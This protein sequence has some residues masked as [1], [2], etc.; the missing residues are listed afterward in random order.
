[1]LYYPVFQRGNT[2]PSQRTNVHR[3]EGKS[4]DEER[5]GH[6]HL[7]YVSLRAGHRGSG[8]L[9]GD[10]EE[11]PGRGGYRHRPH[12]PHRDRRQLRR[13]L[14]GYPAHP[15]ADPPRSSDP[16]EAGRVATESGVSTTAEGRSDEAGGSV[17]AWHLQTSR[18][19]DR[20]RIV[21]DVDLG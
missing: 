15:A 1:M 2:V 6:V 9:R 10:G 16:S 5:T 4:D 14:G 8:V 17:S 7:G 13:G 18:Q 12:R 20:R 21:P 3:L 19:R 11:V